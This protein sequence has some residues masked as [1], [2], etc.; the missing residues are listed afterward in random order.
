VLLAGLQEEIPDTLSAY[1]VLAGIRISDGELLYA[2]SGLPAVG[3]LLNGQPVSGLP[4]LWA[5]AE[6]L[7]PSGV[8]YFS[9]SIDRVNLPH[10]DGITY[11]TPAFG[12]T[13]GTEPGT[14]EF[15]LA[16]KEGKTLVRPGPDTEFE[17]MVVSV[18][19]SGNSN[20][21][22][23]G[24][25]LA[26]SGPEAS[27]LSGYLTNGQTVRLTFQLIPSQW[28]TARDVVPGEHLL[29]AGRVMR[30]LPAGTPAATTPSAHVAFAYNDKVLMF[31]TVDD[32]AAVSGPEWAGAPAGLWRAEGLTLPQLARILQDL[33]MADAI[34]L[35]ARFILRITSEAAGTSKVLPDQGASGPVSTSSRTVGIW[36]TA[37]SGPLFLL[38]VEG[39]ADRVLAGSRFPLQAIGLDAG[40]HPL[41]L[42]PASLSWS[43]LTNN[44]ALEKQGSVAYLVAQAPGR[45]TVRA[46][47][48][49]PEG[50]P[51]QKIWEGE[52]VAQDKLRRITL[53]PAT[54][55]LAPGQS[56]PFT[57]TGW[58]EAGRPVYIDPALLVWDVPASVG[59]FDTATGTLLPS[60]R[61]SGAAS[62][63]GSG[64]VTGGEK[65]E[66]YLGGVIRASL[67]TRPDLSTTA[68]VALGPGPR[69]L[70]DLSTPSPQ[71]L[72]AD[73]QAG[74]LRAVA[75][76]SPRPAT[77]GS[78]MLQPVAK[79]G[80]SA[81][82]LVMRPHPGLAEALTLAKEGRALGLWIYTS[83][84]QA[85][86]LT[87]EWTD[88]A[89]RTLGSS[90]APFNSAGSPL[91]TPVLQ[92][93]RGWHFLVAP[94]PATAT[95]PVT[96]TALRLISGQQ[97]SAALAGEL[98]GLGALLVLFAMPPPASG[99]PAVL[100][101]SFAGDGAAWATVA[102]TTAASSTAGAT[103]A[104]VPSL[105]TFHEVQPADGRAIP[106]PTPR[107]SVRL[108]VA[109]GWELDTA[110]L[111]FSLDGKVAWSRELANSAWGRLV[112][113]EGGFERTSG[114]FWF[115]P[116]QPLLAGRHQARLEFTLIAVD[117]SGQSTAARKT[118]E[119][120]WQFTVA[121]ISVPAVSR[122]RPLRIAVVGGPALAGVADEPAE[123]IFREI[124]RRLNDR[125]ARPDA[126]DLVVIPG[127]ITAANSEPLYK[128]AV[129][130]LQTLK[131]PYLV[132]PGRRDLDLGGN[133]SRDQFLKTW[134]LTCGRLDIST[135][136]L[137]LLDTVEGIGGH[138]PT[139]WDWFARELA[140]GPEGKIR[141]YVIF[142]YRSPLTPL[143]GGTD[144]GWPQAEEPEKLVSLLS[145]VG[146][147]ASASSAGPAKA[148]PGSDTAPEIVF[149][150]GSPAAFLAQQDCGILYLTSGGGGR[151]PEAPPEAGGFYHWLELTLPPD[152]P[153]R[154]S[155]VPLV[156]S[157]TLGGLP[158]KLRV[159]GSVTPWAIADLYTAS[160]SPLR[161]TVQPPLAYKWSVNDPRLASID[162]LTGELT[163]KAPGKVQVTLEVGGVSASKPV[164]IVP[165]APLA[166]ATS[167]G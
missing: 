38:Q 10:S 24:A 13:T 82:E 160:R 144:T 52:V 95:A 44:A 108:Q 115:M 129:Q 94:V 163:G 76:P 2:S 92:L 125:L 58:D 66:A 156:Q 22:A 68:Y 21:P 79:T 36:N 28:R 161:V 84:D 165:P 157:I 116:V 86:G 19:R 140:N 45:V 43:V 124:I 64:P 159:N 81:R 62:S 100:G 148:A 126:P 155:V 119:L 103:S 3:I 87:A 26:V 85:M 123:R 5:K 61:V 93:N 55:L 41:P 30:P 46:E 29:L 48:L 99:T 77:V 35:P 32:T 31:V 53:S 138:D 132:I 117:P 105:V 78:L 42:S 91:K 110:S 47:V 107:F 133:T 6:P 101:A 151:Q 154:W 120:E 128:R 34:S 150:S 88:A 73:P 4:L 158:D 153:A 113:G 50:T 12:K 14:T 112:Y 1:P 146:Q 162:P 145:A 17:A 80:T 20:I 65:G 139:Q 63:S 142:S 167:S 136:R 96:L 72:V 33:G 25:V 131:I 109:P 49:T 111:R 166:R 141:R 39:A 135:T 90:F 70:T 59:H 149:V 143:S 97:N 11:Y 67:R 83:R 23:E 69:L 164:E 102:V 71:W 57:V 75:A 127:D 152:G 118:A 134:G 104:A 18:R 137:L 98:P 40:F 74:Y 89:G 51:V 54:A 9:V 130:L 56:L 121:P 114:V 16:G 106:T 15:V 60:T 147:A 122:T 37:P 7:R 27:R 8:P